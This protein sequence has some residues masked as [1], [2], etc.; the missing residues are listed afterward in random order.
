MPLAS[1]AKIGGYE[2]VA[3]IGAGGM[4]EVYR[5]RD[6]RLGRDVAIKI[7]GPA[8]AGDPEGLRRFE[9]EARM[10]ASLN[11]PNI[12][13][14]YGVDDGHGQPAL[15]LE[16]VDGETLAERI[17]RGPIPVTEAVAYARQIAEALD[18]AHEAGVVH[19]D[20]KPGNIKITENGTV[21]VLDFGLA[22]AIAAAAAPD[23]A[24]DPAHSPTVT[25]HGTKG[26]VILGTA[27]YMSPEQARGKPIDKRTDIWAFGCV[28][29][30][31][32]TGTR[33]FNGE[34]TS[35]VIAAIIERQPEM[36]KL[37]ATVTPHLRQVIARC[38]TKDQRQR[39]RDIG[40]VRVELDASSAAAVSGPSSPRSPWSRTR[41]IVA[42]TI[43]IAIVMVA[44]YG[45]WRSRQSSTARAPM[46]FSFAAPTGSLAVFPAV[47]SP[48]GRRIA[49]IVRE[50]SGATS[51][52]LRSLEAITSRKIDGS[53][54]ANGLMFWSPNGRSLGFTADGMLKHLPV[55]G[56]PVV[57]IAPGVMN[58]GAS[59]NAN[60]EI[61]VAPVNRGPIMRVPAS[62]GEPVAVTRLDPAK[63]NSHRWPH[64]LPDG[65]HFLFT[66]RSDKPENQGIKV[67]SLDSPEIKRLVNAPSPGIF[68][69]PGLL[70]YVT[71]DAVLMAQPFDLKTLSL[72][73]VPRPVTDNVR[74]VGPSAG[75]FFA[76]SRD[77]SVLTSLPRTRAQARLVW[78]DCQG[79]ELGALGPERNY[80]DLR[81]SPDGRHVAV[82]VTDDRYA[83]RDLWIVDVATNALTRVTSNPATDWRP[84]WA[85]DGSTLVFASDRAG[86]S[87][88]FRVD[89]ATQGGETL[90]YRANGGAFPSDWSRASDRLTIQV[91]D[92]D[93]RPTAIHIVRPDGSAAAPPITGSSR[94]NFPRFSPEGD[95]ISF[96]DD[97]TGAFETYVMS[98]ADGRRIRVSTEGGLNSMWSRSGQELFYVTPEGEVMSVALS[99][100]TTGAASAPARLFRPCQ[101]AR[102]AQLFAAVATE[103]I[104]DV[105]SDGSRFLARCDPADSIPAAVTVATDWQA[106]LR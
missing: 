47:P 10:L 13:A 48:D 5:A 99:A 22:K 4:G 7:V 97:A 57:T 23:P 103:L 66:V 12:A 80:G 15:I 71:A 61:I 90:L 17:A 75:A 55:D 2:I 105:A 21:K 74:H 49:F 87:S 63:E 85:P 3:L 26:G 51:I 89:T 106:R 101:T 40:D 43:A 65:R 8:I 96:Q 86:L 88:V 37:P 60:D 25:V 79:R 35:D 31:M 44:A 93:G 59:W 77:G 76:A 24:L 53:Q 69:E 58:L 91:D 36:S 62:G 6:A 39:A 83:T 41:L 73:G 28:L 92:A 46:E 102:G 30:E 45:G 38:L 42:S 84:V 1:G 67:G 81:I 82:V 32:L 29:Y 11:H 94:L 54:G 50:E 72:T 27:A 68:V 70:L 56:G 16:L 98:L 18:A 104:I 34:T 19:R 78:F 9:R 20:L 95:R 33:V 52:W 64:F 14:I 100:K